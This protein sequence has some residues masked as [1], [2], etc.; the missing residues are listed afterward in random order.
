MKGDVRS[1]YSVD[2]ALEEEDQKVF[3]RRILVSFKQGFHHKLHKRIVG[4]SGQ[5]QV[6]KQASK[7]RND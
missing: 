6:G 5:V 2:D 7:R 3:E 1:S 4:D